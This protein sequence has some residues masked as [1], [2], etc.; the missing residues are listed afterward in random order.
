MASGAY[1]SVFYH[2]VPNGKALHQL[3]TYVYVYVY[4]HIN[5]AETWEIIVKLEDVSEYQ[6]INTSQRQ[7]VRQELHHAMQ[8]KDAS[9]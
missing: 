4:V 5:P 1:R 2:W 6:C 3:C 7:Q 9:F 8:R